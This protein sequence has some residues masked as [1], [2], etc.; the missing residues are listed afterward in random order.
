MIKLI[1][2]CQEIQYIQEKYRCGLFL[3]TNILRRDVA[4]QRLYNNYEITATVELQQL[5]NYNIFERFAHKKM[6]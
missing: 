5:R 6:A 4:V 2:M 3:C 1:P